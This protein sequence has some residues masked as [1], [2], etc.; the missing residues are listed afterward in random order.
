[1]KIPKLYRNI[2]IE[3]YWLTDTCE[4]GEHVQ[5]DGYSYIEARR[6][7][8][9]DNNWFWQIHPY[10]KDE[11]KAVIEG[12]EPECWLPDV[13]YKSPFDFD[14][15]NLGYSFNRRTIKEIKADEISR[16]NF[17]FSDTPF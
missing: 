12:E 2:W 10:Y 1:M 4:G 17:D 9:T 16:N 5:R 15:R 13:L 3:I 14:E 11:F 6:A 7:L 8:D